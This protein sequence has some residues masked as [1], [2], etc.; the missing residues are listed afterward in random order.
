[1]ARQA[2]TASP[3]KA[4]VRHQLP[5][6]VVTTTFPPPHRAFSFVV[7]VDAH[8]MTAPLA[9]GAVVGALQ[10]CGDARA[11]VVLTGDEYLKPQVHKRL[12]DLGLVLGATENAGALVVPGGEARRF[13]AN[14]WC[15]FTRKRR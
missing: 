2:M 6:A 9:L 4:P 10:E 8:A 11:V 3:A 7:T 5:R 1:M 14:L 13:V 12:E 15:L